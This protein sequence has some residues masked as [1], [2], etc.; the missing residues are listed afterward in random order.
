MSD[1]IWSGRNALVWMLVSDTIV[2][3]ICTNQH[4][5]EAAILMAK[6]TMRNDRRI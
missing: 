2:Q 5:Q 4:I 3:V 1:S 6:N